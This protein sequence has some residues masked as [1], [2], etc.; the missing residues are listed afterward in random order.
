MSLHA[1]TIFNNTVM[2]AVVSTN[3][4]HLPR[5]QVLDP[6]QGVEEKDKSS[7]GIDKNINDNEMQSTVQIITQ[8]N[9]DNEKTGRNDERKTS[10]S[11]ES[12]MSTS[13]IAGTSNTPTDTLQPTSIIN[14]A[15]NNDT[16]PTNKKNTSVVGMRFLPLITLGITVPMVVSE[17]MLKLW[18][19]IGNGNANYLFFQGLVMWVFLATALIEFTNATIRELDD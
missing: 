14:T 15:T 13:V 2:K 3:L 12:K 19:A 10:E 17:T 5:E 18:T 6:L 9:A 7:I 8:H 16:T 11:G 4:P 1:E